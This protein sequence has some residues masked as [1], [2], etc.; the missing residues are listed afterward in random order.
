MA[1]DRLADLKRQYP[2]FFSPSNAEFHEEI[3]SLHDEALRKN[4][5]GAETVKS[6][7]K[8][9]GTHRDAR[10]MLGLAGSALEKRQ[11]AAAMLAVLG[12]TLSDHAAHAP[13]LLELAQK[14]IE[15]SQNAELTLRAINSALTKHGM[16]ANAFFEL[17]TRSLD[18]EQDAARNVFAA[19]NAIED[20]YGS[21]RRLRDRTEEA[22]LGGKSH[23]VFKYANWAM[24]SGLNAADS[25]KDYNPTASRTD[26]VAQR[27][28]K[29][30]RNLIGKFRSRF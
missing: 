21:K 20:H 25:L 30:L 27:L 16:H 6:L 9:M 12:E 11:D 17:A 29:G 22:L 13:Q 1:Y 8:A 26:F 5:N 28:E 14:T 4:Q 2:H 19:S 23:H 3:A 7:L 24:D 15:N 10:K 18:A